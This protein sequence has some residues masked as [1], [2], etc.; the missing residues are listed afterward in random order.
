MELFPGLPNDLG[1][2]CLLLVSYESHRNLRAVCKSWEATVNDSSFYR[3][4]KKLGITQQC[5]CLFE[6]RPC[7]ATNGEEFVATVYDP[8]EATWETLPRL[9]HFPGRH[10]GIPF[11][12]NCISVNQKLLFLGGLIRF[13]KNLLNT[14]F[15]YDFSSAKWSLG[16]DSPTARRAAAFSVSPE[17]HWETCQPLKKRATISKHKNYVFGKVRWKDKNGESY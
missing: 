13:E 8:V 16:A 5:I 10:N 2:L 6:L 9:P 1:R 17:G 11:F 12:S 3:D 15:I 4:R 7:R 14:V